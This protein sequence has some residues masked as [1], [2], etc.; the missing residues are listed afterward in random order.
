MSERN[1]PLLNYRYRVEID[2]LVVAGFSEVSGLVT[3]IETEEYKEGGAD[4]VHKLP[5]GIKQSNIVLKKGMGISNDL[6]NWYG[7]V[8]NALTYGKP[9]PKSESVYISVIDEKGEEKIRF[10]IK[11]A[12]PVKWSGPELKGTGSDVA[13]ETIEL[14]HE[15]MVKV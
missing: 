1:F 8:V 6:M 3:E 13:I 10:L 4:F 14:V 2:G 12:Y 7:A 5:G 11:R 9:L 15:G